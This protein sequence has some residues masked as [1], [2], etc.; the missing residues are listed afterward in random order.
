V[1][2][3]RLT[4][5]IPMNTIAIFFRIRSP[6]CVMHSIEGHDEYKLSH[7]TGCR[8][9]TIAQ[10]ARINPVSSLALPTR[11]WILN[12]IL[13]LTLSKMLARSFAGE[14]M[15]GVREAGSCAAACGE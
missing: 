8:L 15:W 7:W 6:L 3:G 11:W 10:V 1:A 13:G 9:V 5:P 14:R 12:W 2:L 4:N